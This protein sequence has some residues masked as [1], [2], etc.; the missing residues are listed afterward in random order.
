MNIFERI[1][2]EIHDR[3]AQLDVVDFGSK[4]IKG[5]YVD[6]SIALNKDLCNNAE[7]TCVAAEELAHH[8]LTVGNI[9][10]MHDIQNRKQEYTSRLAAY[11]KLIG[12]YGII[13]GYKARC[14]NR[15]ELA[16][17][18]E[19]T[20][21]FLQDALNCYHSKYG[22]MAQIDNYIIFFEPGIAVLER[23]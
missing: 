9:L 4:R 20:E 10:N 17:H 23:F 6:G 11:N 19:V 1:E 13:S 21:D 22:P 18:L 3:G 15:F 14:R 16:T 5:L 2:Q 7:R 8:E 12:L